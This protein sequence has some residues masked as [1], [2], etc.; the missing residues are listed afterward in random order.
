MFYYTIST[1]VNLTETRKQWSRDTEE[2]GN[3]FKLFLRGG[4]WQDL[5]ETP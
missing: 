5:T 2:K 1:F 4:W 3:L